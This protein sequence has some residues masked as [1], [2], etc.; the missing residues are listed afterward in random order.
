MQER[1]LPGYDAHAD[2]CGGAQ[3]LYLSASVILCRQELKAQAPKPA[4][5]ATTK[6]KKPAPFPEQPFVSVQSPPR[7]KGRAA[8]LLRV[9]TRGSRT[10]VETTD[11]DLTVIQAVV[12]QGGRLGMSPRGWGTCKQRTKGD[13][14]EVTRRKDLVSLYPTQSPSLLHRVLKITQRR[15][16]IL[17]LHLNNLFSFGANTKGKEQECCRS[18]E[19]TCLCRIDGAEN[20]PAQCTLVYTHRSFISRSSLSR[21]MIQKEGKSSWGLNSYH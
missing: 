14:T 6:R 12:G 10:S 9:G 4:R 19:I 13:C 2:C 1:F 8:P 18:T 16:Q 17:H 20:R 15:R 7:S 5:G 11:R 3:A 21:C